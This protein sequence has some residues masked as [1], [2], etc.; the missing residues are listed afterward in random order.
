MFVA[1]LDR[2]ITFVAMECM[3]IYFYAVVAAR[4]VIIFILECVWPSEVIDEDDDYSKRAF[5][6][7]SFE[8]VKATFNKAVAVGAKVLDG[9]SKCQVDIYMEDICMARV[10][11]PYCFTWTI[12]TQ[13]KK[14]GYFA[15]L[16]AA[17]L[18]KY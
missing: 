3:L 1:V 10:K 4:S 18:Y 17:L 8:D 13:P 2:D 7:K 6:V 12:Q 15:N 16:W 11:D 5:Y 9:V 14:K